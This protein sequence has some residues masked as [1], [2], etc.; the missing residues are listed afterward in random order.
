MDNFRNSVVPSSVDQEDIEPFR[1]EIER[2]VGWLEPQIEINRTS[3]GSSPFLGHCL[4]AQNE[5]VKYLL[6]LERPFE[7]LSYP[8]KLECP[9]EYARGEFALGLESRW[10]DPWATL[11]LA[12]RKVW[13]DRKRTSPQHREED[14]LPKD[15]SSPKGYELGG[16]RS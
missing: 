1:M 9:F 8:L 15:R 7:L 4:D 12:M 10:Q 3:Q 5:A 13:E 14:I 11:G 2:R 16:E 6:G